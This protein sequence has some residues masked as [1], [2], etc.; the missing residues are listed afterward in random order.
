MT[1]DRHADILALH[2][3]KSRYFRY[4]DTKQWGRWRTLFSDDLRFF[5]EDSVLPQTQV[6]ITVGGDEFVEYVSDLI[7]GAVTIHQGHMPE[8]DFTGPHTA[9]GIWAM[10]DFVDYGPGRSAFQGY[11][12]YHEDY[13]R[14]ADGQWRIKVLR[15]TRIRVDEQPGSQP[16]GARPSVAPWK[17]TDPR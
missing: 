6:P 11:G 17:R 13:E 14:G 15:L 9:R 4:M 16:A 7:T 8:I 5:M 1:A 12:H 3:L 2:Q 10:Y